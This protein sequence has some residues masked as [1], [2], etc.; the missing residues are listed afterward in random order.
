M[1]APIERV[2]DALRELD[3]T[4]DVEI[5]FEIGRAFERIA[6]NEAVRDSRDVCRAVGALETIYG[7]PTDPWKIP[8]FTTKDAGLYHARNVVVAALQRALASKSPAKSP[9]SESAIGREA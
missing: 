4:D 6:F 3:I 5:A 9:A 2:R 7:L 1:T 8:G